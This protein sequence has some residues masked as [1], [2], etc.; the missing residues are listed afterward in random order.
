LFLVPAQAAG[1]SITKLSAVDCRN[2]AN[3]DFVN[4]DVPASA[5]L[6][7]STDALARVIDGATAGL[8]AEMLGSTQEAFD[9]TVA[10]LKV[11]K[12]F[13]VPIGSFQ[14]LKHRA[15]QMFCELELSKSVVLDALR[16]VDADRPD[17][18]A[19]V[20]AAKARVNDTFV[21]V[22]SEAI[23]MHGGMGATDELDVG[24]FYKRA[25]VAEMTLGSSTYHRD[26]FARLSGY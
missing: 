15:A 4:V 25:R 2:V 17:A 10:Y 11:R 20:S 26:R 19:V 9:V 6:P 12:Q 3:V 14:A 21:L 23:Q 7:G 5:L 13:G 18:S 24:F 8:C 1:V 16:A 22:A